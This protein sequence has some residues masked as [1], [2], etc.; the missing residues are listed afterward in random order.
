MQTECYIIVSMQDWLLDFIVSNA[1]LISVLILH[2]EYLVIDR[3]YVVH[4][5]D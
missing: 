3:I 4:V 2:Y 5:F 1:M